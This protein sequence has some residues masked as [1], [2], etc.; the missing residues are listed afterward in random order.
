MLLHLPVIKPAE[1]LTPLL[2][3]TLELLLQATATV[4]NPLPYLCVW[5]VCFTRLFKDV[6]TFTTGVVFIFREGHKMC[7]NFSLFENLTILYITLLRFWAGPAYCF[8]ILSNKEKLGHIFCPL[9]LEISLLLNQ[10]QAIWI[11]IFNLPWVILLDRATQLVDAET[12]DY[13][14]RSLMMRVLWTGV[15]E[16]LL[17]AVSP[18]KLD[19]S[20]KGSQLLLLVL[21]VL[22]IEPYFVTGLL[23]DGV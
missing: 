16:G 5:Y 21:A 8:I 11:V 13:H 20:S 15:G 14:P 1:K 10:A 6:F 19:V 22:V 3:H 7:P 17:G 23:L 9:I 2:S 4:S 12:R 18:F